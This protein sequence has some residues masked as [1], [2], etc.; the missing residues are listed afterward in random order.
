MRP[1]KRCSCLMSV[2]DGQSWTEATCLGRRLIL[3]SST[4][5]P[6]HFREGM[7]KTNLAELTFKPLSCKT[8]KNCWRWDK[9]YC[10]VRLAMRWLSRHVKTNGRWQHNLSMRHWNDWAVFV[11]PNGIKGAQT[12]HGHDDGG[13]LDA[14]CGYGD[15]VVP[16]HQVYTWKNLQPWR[17]TAKSSMEGRWYRSDLVNML[18]RV[19]VAVIAEGMPRTIKLGYH[20]ERQWPRG[21]RAV[22][23]T[24]SFQIA[25]LSLINLQLIRIQAAWFGKHRAASTKWRMPWRSCGIPLPCWVMQPEVCG[26]PENE[27]FLVRKWILKIDW[28][29]DG[30]ELPAVAAWFSVQLQGAWHLRTFTPYWSLLLE[31]LDLLSWQPGVGQRWGCWPFLSQRWSGDLAVQGAAV[32]RQSGANQNSGQWLRDGGDRRWSL[33]EDSNRRKRARK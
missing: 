22:D 3:A 7:A 28:T 30:T 9:C 33:M 16:F 31:L 25:K 27:K 17:L 19:C 8:W 29:D 12:T 2:G 1:R 23:N 6:T 11:K 32:M 20:M 18:R 4:M 5:W 13:L 21:K 14:L 15:L 24:C 26:L 10:S